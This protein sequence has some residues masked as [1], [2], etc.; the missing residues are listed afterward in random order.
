LVVGIATS[1]LQGALPGSWNRLANSGSAWTLI[2]FAVAVRVARNRSEAIGAGLFGLLGSVAG[3]YALAAPIRGIATT[4]SERLLWTLAALVVGPVAGF[5]AD[6][7]AR[8][9]R[10][11]HLSAGL[12][13]CGVVV[14]EALHAIARISSTDPAGWT[15]FVVGVVA[16]AVMCRDVRDRREALVAGGFGVAVT[17]IVFAVYGQSLLR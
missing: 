16:A 15:E 8:G 1:Y 6:A 13:V 3:Y 11:Q 7:W 12:A 4:W 10:L 17:L 5:A 2:A 14:G 9:S